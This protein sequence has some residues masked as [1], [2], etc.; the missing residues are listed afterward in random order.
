M[1][2]MP[3]L[4]R[5]ETYRARALRRSSTSAERALWELLR[6]RRFLG[7]KFR[8]QHPIG[9]YTVDFF[10]DEVGLVIEADGARHFPRPKRDIRRDRWLESLGLTVLRFPNREILHVPQRV[11]ERIRDT[12]ACELR[13]SPFGRGATG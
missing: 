4:L 10:C 6:N 2:G 8:R 9:P 11:L 12:I 13:P 7:L 1:E 3:P 5:A